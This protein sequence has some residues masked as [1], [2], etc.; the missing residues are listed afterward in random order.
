MTFVPINLK[1][2]F[3]NHAAIVSLVNNTKPKKSE[4]CITFKWWQHFHVTYS[5]DLLPFRVTAPEGDSHL[6]SVW[7]VATT[8][9]SC[10]PPYMGHTVF[11]L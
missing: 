11:Q 6:L 9:K 10:L 8:P 5:F 2:Q 3:K 7:G 4:E 1:N